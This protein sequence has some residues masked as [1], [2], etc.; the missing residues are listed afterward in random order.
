MRLGKDNKEINRRERIRPHIYVSFDIEQVELLTSG[1]IMVS[2][3]PYGKT[4]T[5]NHTITT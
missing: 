5:E 3:N 2:R 1:G 4:K